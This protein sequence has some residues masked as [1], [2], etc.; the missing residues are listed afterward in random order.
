MDFGQKAAVPVQSIAGCEAGEGFVC[1]KTAACTDY[2][3]LYVHQYTLIREGG[4][5]SLPWREGRADNS[6]YQPISY[7]PILE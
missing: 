2:E 7:H 3:D 5:D 4:R 6:H 1:A